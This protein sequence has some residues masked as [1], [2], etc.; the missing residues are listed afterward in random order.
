MKVYTTISNNKRVIRMA[1]HPMNEAPNM[2]TGDDPTWDFRVAYTGTIGD[3]EWFKSC[4]G[5]LTEYEDG[6]DDITPVVPLASKAIDFENGA[7]IAWLL[8]EE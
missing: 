8:A 6:G 1:L 7:A 4:R 2:G 3:P 5:R